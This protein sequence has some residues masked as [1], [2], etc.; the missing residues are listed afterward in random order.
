M[1][2]ITVVKKNGVAAIAADTL[3]KWGYI[4]ESSDYI[5]NHQKII[6]VGDS[7]I[8]AT[9]SMTFGQS[10]NDYLKSPT[11][12]FSLD[13]KED[14]FSSWNRLHQALKENYYLNAEED[15]EDSFEST[16]ANV[17]IANPMGIFGV[18]SHRAVQEFTM[19]YSYGAGCEFA[20]GAMYVAYND[21]RYGAEQIA[22]LGVEASAE[23]DDSTGTP[24]VSYT[25]R[26]R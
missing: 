15:E 24:V 2:T 1:S 7:Y 22:R 16:R 3:T 12:E 14:I 19:F 10:L 6:K 18:G 11:A 23:F 5:A 4:K 9:G 13:S 21:E 26:L 8:G 25:V 20:L 17:L